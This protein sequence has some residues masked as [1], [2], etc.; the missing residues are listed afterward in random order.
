MD[1]TRKDQRQQEQAEGQS[2]TISEGS[3]IISMAR[4]ISKLI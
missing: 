4:S 2:S 1:N 3:V